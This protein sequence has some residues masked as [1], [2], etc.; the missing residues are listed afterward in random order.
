MLLFFL[1]SSF[2]L[3]YFFI[4]FHPILNFLCCRYFVCW[5]RMESLS[6]ITFIWSSLLRAQIIWVDLLLI[7]FWRSQLELLDPSRFKLF[8]LFLQ[9]LFK[10]FVQRLKV[11]NRIGLNLH[12][13]YLIIFLSKLLHDRIL[14]WV[15][16]LL[17][18][19]EE[20]WKFVPASN[21]L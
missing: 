13:F 16:V 8:F 11:W 10:L 5:W 18:F 21:V 7:H 20:I 6:P 19:E 17:I 2:I 3:L 14:G 12:F 9:F 4:V 1:E 15:I